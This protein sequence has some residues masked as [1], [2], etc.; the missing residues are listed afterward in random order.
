MTERQ[1]MENMA[2]EG[3]TEMIHRLRQIGEGLRKE[4]YVYEGMDGRRHPEP[5]GEWNK[6]ILGAMALDMVSQSVALSNSHPE[7]S[8]HCTDWSAE[9]LKLGK[10][11]ACMLGEQ[12]RQTEEWPQEKV[13][14]ILGEMKQACV[15]GP[16]DFVRLC[17]AWAVRLTY[18]STWAN[19][20]ENM[21]G[22]AERLDKS[23]ELDE[24]A[25]GLMRILVKHHYRMAEMSTKTYLYS[26]DHKYLI[27]MM[28][29]FTIMEHLI[30]EGESEP[31]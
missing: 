6:C 8:R 10:T 16:E 27:D 4:D 22:A 23:K 24:T 12:I 17:R 21:W 26:E 25:H 15:D 20:M 18:M 7:I 11:F 5:P 9:F 29:R 13:N 2:A 28:W 30:L 3:I 31:A 19:A 14:E 1:Q